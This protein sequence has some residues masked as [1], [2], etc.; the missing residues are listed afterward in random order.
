MPDQPVSHPSRRTLIA[1]AGGWL[2]AG[3]VRAD[4]SAQGPL[5]FEV[6]RDGHAIGRHQVR[7]RRD[8][9][10]LTAIQAASLVVKLGP[11]PVFR[12]RHD[13]VERWEAGR[14]ARLETTTVTNGR[15]EQV[16]ATAGPGGVRIESAHGLLV[17]P[18]DAAPLTHWNPRALDRPLFN[19]QTGR[20]LKVR[21]SR[22]TDDPPP[23]PGVA[24]AFLWALRGETE[25]DDWYDADSVW[26]ALR[27]RA[28]DGSV[29]EYRRVEG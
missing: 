28:P 7:F 2:A 22:R 24:A 27:G 4:P 6:R 25:I 13:A 21:A 1:A 11:I 9:A 10:R 17:A 16:T 12:Y 5:V 19:P 3:P 18:A 29:L 23:F 26:L 15:R 20:M 8:G 14:F